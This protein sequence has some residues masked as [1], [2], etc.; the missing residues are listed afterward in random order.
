MLHR[1]GA[2]IDAAIAVQ[3]V[4]ALVEPQASGLGGGSLLLTWDAAPIA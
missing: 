2:P 1:G 3:A 4:L